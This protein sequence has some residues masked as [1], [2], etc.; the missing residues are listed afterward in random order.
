MP[1]KYG[2]IWL[3]YFKQGDDMGH[4]I[5]KDNDGKIDALKS[6]QNHI[7]LLQL[8]ID[9]LTQ[10]KNE[11]P[12]VND[13]EIDGD[14]HHISISGDEKIMQILIDKKL[15]EEEEFSNENSDDNEDGEENEDS[16]ENEDD[17]ENDNKKDIPDP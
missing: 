14:T 2:T 15:V 7:D 9:H 3:S 8:A 12:Q 11:I 16:E 6:I 17:E 5:V 4:S 1:N 10:I 13:I